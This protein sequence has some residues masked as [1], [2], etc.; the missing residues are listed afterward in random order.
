MAPALEPTVI[1]SLSFKH[2]SIR[3]R[4][5]ARFRIE[6]VAG[7]GGIFPMN[8]ITILLADDHALVR[9]G[10]RTLLE[11][12]QNLVVVA[13]AAN[14]REAVDLARA[15]RP[16]LVIT[17]VAMPLLNGFEATRQIRSTTPGT[18]VLALSAYDCDEYVE[19]MIH[20]GASGY[21]LK[22]NA[23]Q[24]LFRA[25]RAIADGHMFFSPAVMKRLEDV[26]RSAQERGEPFAVGRPSLSA[27]ETEVLQLVAEGAANK[28]MAA[29]LGISIK[30][31]EK[32]RQQLMN[33][34]G[35]HNIAGLTRHAIGAGLTE[36]SFPLAAA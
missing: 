26:A 6:P 29:E 11:G 24:V 8:T 9:K 7:E 30:T 18:R 34:L 13:E 15:V 23:A 14:G 10:L 2:T 3:S 35:I 12:E 17:D 33:K 36:P 25:V 21:I 22:Q 1:P 19:R 20:V 27:R 4:S 32:H 5:I 16:S 28:Q 31:V